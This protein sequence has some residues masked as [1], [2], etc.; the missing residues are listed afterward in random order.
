MARPRRLGPQVKRGRVAYGPE[1]SGSR[2]VDQRLVD[3]L[4]QLRPDRIGTRGHELSEEA[5]R[6]LL[7]RVDPEGGAGRAA[8]VEFARRAQRLGRRGVELDG[9]AKPESHPLE[10]RLGVE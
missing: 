8:P 5:D 4:A 1:V 3:E 7:G 6:Q 9:E 10:D 2:S